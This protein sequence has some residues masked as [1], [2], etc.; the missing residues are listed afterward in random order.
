MWIR[1]WFGAVL[2]AV[3]PFVVFIF[4][5]RYRLR[6]QHTPLLTTALIDNFSGLSRWA[7]CLARLDPC[8]RHWASIRSLRVYYIQIVQGLNKSEKGLSTLGLY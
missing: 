8:L 3:L 1:C 7:A 5:P 2:V 6:V 4:L